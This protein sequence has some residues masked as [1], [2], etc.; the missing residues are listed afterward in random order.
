MSEKRENEELQ[1]TNAEEEIID[2]PETDETS[3][4]AF[5]DEILNEQSEHETISEGQNDDD[6]SK[7]K[8]KQG[9][10]K[11]FWAKYKSNKKVAIP[12]TILVVVLIL[13]IIPFTRYK[14]LGLFV[15]RTVYMTVVD[16]QTGKP[17]SEVDVSVGGQSAKTNGDGKATINSVKVGPQTFN[18]SKKYYQ[19]TSVKFTVK[20][21]GQNNFEAKMQATGRQVPITVTNKINNQPIKGATIKSGD[22]QAQTDT[23]G[24]AVLVLDPD[25]SQ[26]KAVITA[27]GYN[28][29]EIEVKVTENQDDANKFALT[30]A[31]KVYFLSKKSGKIDVVKTNLDGTDRAT[32]VDGTG[33]EQDFDTVLLASRDWKYLV[34]KAKRDNSSKLYLINTE[35]DKTTVIENN[36]GNYIPAGWSNNKFVYTLIKNSN[37]WEPGQQA[38]KS[39]DA[40]TGQLRVLDESKAE[41]SSSDNYAA[42]NYGQIYI[43]DNLLVYNKTWSAG[44]LSYAML[45][46]KRMSIN[47]IRPDSSNKK[48]LRDFDV[49]TDGSSYMT[50]KLYE[51]E[52][53]YYQV[54]QQGN[55][56]TYFKYENGEVRPASDITAAKFDSFYPTYLISP[57]G[58][59]TFWSEPR[60]GKFSLFIGGKNAEDKKEIGS[61]SPY[62]AYGWFTDDYLLLSKSD[63]ELYIA[64]VSKPEQTMLISNY[65]KANPDFVGYGYGYGGQ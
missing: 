43:L 10:I 22:S 52:E 15:K 41:G 7:D 36:D 48:N 64:P 32:V 50:G 37:V 28:Q 24:K 40:E 42:E 17:V 57:S 54:G 61:L 45:S 19:S 4:V 60:D 47:S 8:S 34:L 13:M 35:N 16:Q 63:S 26:E 6:K 59:K 12:L 38:L 21:K 25:S 33:N 46:G 31:G 56:I 65:H 55:T 1:P 58:N 62:K 11:K 49:A 9:R 30:P 39:Y 2:I 5:E 51:P 3:E 29:T 44:Y 14:I 20:L 53:I 27:S 23:T 18:L